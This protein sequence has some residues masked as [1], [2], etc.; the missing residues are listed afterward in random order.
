MS[1]ARTHLR[2]VQRDLVGARDEQ[3]MRVVAM[4]DAMSAR[5]DADALIAPLRAR[6]EQLRP[7]RRLNFGRLMFAPLDPLFLPGR[8]WRRGTPGVPRTALAPLAAVARA[9]IGTDAVA[10]DARMEGVTAANTEAVR[11]LGAVLWPRAAAVLATATV[12]ADWNESTGL[13]TADFTALAVPV[14]AVLAQASAVQEIT[15][16][17]KSGSDPSDHEL[18]G[19]LARAMMV[20]ASAMTMMFALLM[21]QLPRPERLILIAEDLAGRETDP[22]A[23]AAADRAADFV[24]DRI[25]ADV[26]PGPHLAHAT[27]DIRRVASVLQDLE[28]RSTQRPTRRARI[29]QL[30]QQ[31]DAK[32][33]ERFVA[34]L[35]SQLLAPAGSLAGAAGDMVAAI[36]ATARDLR[37]FEMV[38]R[39]V[40]GG[41]AY[42]R[43]LRRATEMLQPRPD[44]SP[45]TFVDRVRLIEILQGPEAAL[46]VLAAA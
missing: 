22:I 14:A 43:Q 24:L 6:L 5:G 36:E 40:G 27:D 46:A 9:A 19:V 11:A 45:A 37:R 38:A 8:A 32:C 12:P 16:R 28:T 31:F 21:A 39:Q 1:G 3:I 13:Q 30:R 2:S 44:E 15:R 17:A 7:P 41:E 33:R 10:L 25:E 42:D 35:D 26:G 4:V 18:E 29:V 20:D 23:R 34:E